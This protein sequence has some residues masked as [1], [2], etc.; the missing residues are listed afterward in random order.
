MS[1]GQKPKSWIATVVVSGA[2]LGY[3]FLVFVPIQESIASL[4]T[5]LREQIKYVGRSATVDATIADLERRKRA[6]NQV[7]Q[8]W[9]D[10]APSEHAM[11]TF[12]GA[13]SELA[14]QAGAK[15]GRITPGNAITLASLRIYPAEL[16]VEG[17]F[18]EIAAFLASLERRDET[19]WI[20]NLN[21]QPIEN[22]AKLTC[23]V[24][25]TVFADKLADSD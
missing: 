23:Q 18:Y 1:E 15:A 21:V 14:E 2:S 19:I 5:E 10:H 17:D 3:V 16:A 25:F 9:R 6:A 20:T 22:T 11:A 24:R 8:R 7:V 4:R 13:V 12:I